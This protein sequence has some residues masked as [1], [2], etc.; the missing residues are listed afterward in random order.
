V[1]RIEGLLPTDESGDAQRHS[2]KRDEIDE[3][4][5]AFGEAWR[6]L[7]GATGYLPV[8]LL[9]L[10]SML[11]IPLLG[12]SPQGALFNV[13]LISGG[14][15]LTIF[16]STSRP[17]LRRWAWVFVAISAGLAA[18][19]ILTGDPADHVRLGTILGVV[20]LMMLLACFPLVLVR[21]FQHRKVTVNTVCATLSAYL[22]IG[23][24]FMAA[25]R[26]MG[27]LAAPFFTQPGEV[28]AGQYAYFS[29]ITLTTVGYGDLTPGSDAARSIV[30][31]E[32]VIG[33]VFLVT[34]MARVVSLLGEERR[35]P[36]VLRPSAGDGDDVVTPSLSDEIVN[37]ITDAVVADR[38][39]SS[40]SAASGAE[41]PD[42]AG[43]DRGG[44]EGGDAVPARDAPTG[45]A[46]PMSPHAAA[47]A[48]ARARGTRSRDIDPTPAADP[49]GTP[50][51]A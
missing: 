43:G 17:D 2:H 25:Y 28:T 50:P 9:I 51:P 49:P 33:Q 22:L 14:L 29:F 26:L 21:S 3:V 30:M 42:D 5:S 24:I 23:L 38:R 19:A 18:V 10:A 44:G 20:Y 16:R 13:L 47:A 8:L 48:A 11:S 37:R 4:E 40:R 35:A 45:P 15:L 41:A 34:T 39:Q 6:N 36:L 27:L 32:A 46:R 7:T 12:D 31:L 1:R